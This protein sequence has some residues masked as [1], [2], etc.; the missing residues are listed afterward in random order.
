MG[1][2]FS[3]MSEKVPKSVLEDLRKA[4][5][6][7]PVGIVRELT[8]AGYEAYIVGGAVRDLLLGKQPKDYDISTSATPEEVRKVFGRRRCHVIGRR[9][10]LAHVYANGEI[11]EVSTFR[12]TPNERER[13]GRKHDDGPIIWNDNCFGTLVEDAQRRDF[14]VNAL[15]LDVAGT[16]GVIDFS[17]GYADLREGI[18]RCIGNPAQRMDEDPVRMLRALKLVGQCGFILEPHLEAVIRAKASGIKLSSPARLF[19]ELLKLLANPSCDQTL[20]VMHEHG[21]LREFW[22]IVD[23]AWDEQ[24]GVMMRHLLKL[25]GDAIR[26][27]RYSNSRGL[28]LS[29]VLLPFMMSALNPENPIAFWEGNAAADPIAHKALGVVFEGITVPRLLSQR[30]LQIVGLV[31]RLLKKPVATRFLNHAEYRYGRALVAL[32]VQLFGW[33]PAI[34]EDLP[35]FSPRFDSFEDEGE[36]ESDD[37]FWVDSTAETETG[38]APTAS[39][40]TES[41]SDE[42][43]VVV[44]PKYPGLVPLTKTPRKRSVGKKSGSPKEIGMAVLSESEEAPAAPKKTRSRSKKSSRGKAASSSPNDPENSPALNLPASEPERDDVPVVEA[45]PAAPAAAF[46]NSVAPSKHPGKSSRG[47]RKSP[48][49]SADSI[50]FG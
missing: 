7:T 12:R 14:T 4:V 23:A 1:I 22:P 49:P 30:I 43:A 5:N 17:N 27:G 36:E 11:Y 42:E 35:E 19:E 15:Y 41:E 31:P 13:Q 3:S 44:N 29:T 38:L 18:V 20:Q 39:S 47:S 26:R 25:R 16:R 46:F 6:P 34:L 8:R 48:S 28:A 40:A 9:F 2:K 45:P 50:T 21:L 33:D 32:L 37:T 10:R 24:E